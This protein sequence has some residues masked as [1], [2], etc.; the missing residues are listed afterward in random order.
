MA[1]LLAEGLLNTVSP[2]TMFVNYWQPLGSLK[3]E[4]L[5]LSS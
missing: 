3:A 2:R 5:S 4:H 1:A